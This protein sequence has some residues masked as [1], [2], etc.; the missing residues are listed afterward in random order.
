MKNHDALLQKLARRVQSDVGGAAMPV[1]K[2]LRYICNDCGD[3]AIITMLDADPVMPNP[4]L[5][6]A[7]TLV[8]NT[9]DDE[10]RSAL[11]GMMEPFEDYRGER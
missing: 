11:R 3:T 9:A 10:L 2:R 8:N 7:C 6:Q 1:V 5:C 4:R